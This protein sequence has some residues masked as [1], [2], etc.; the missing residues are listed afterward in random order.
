MVVM[1]LSEVGESG[2]A[3]S[4]FSGEMCERLFLKEEEVRDQNASKRNSSI[5]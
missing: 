2:S 1:C 3:E 5:M 4:Q